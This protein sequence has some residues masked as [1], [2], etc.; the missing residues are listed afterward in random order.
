MQDPNSNPY[1]S[2]SATVADV[3]TEGYE[4]A[5]LGLRLLGAII[6]TLILLLLIVPLMFATGY[7]NSIMSGV[8][9]GFFEQLKM[10]AMGFGVFL[11]LQGYFLNATGQTIGKKILGTKIVT[12]DNEK[13]EIVKLILTRYAILHVINHIP[14]V[15]G[16]FGLVN[17][18]FI[19]FGDQRQC[20]HD[21]F[22][23]TKVVMAK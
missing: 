10:G 9:P 17:V 13:P 1:A 5:S 19:F 14:F 6:D 8:Q 4:L 16:L 2:P 21:K 23:G 12:M 7:I 3:A 18:I 20:L 15:G 11:L 22:A